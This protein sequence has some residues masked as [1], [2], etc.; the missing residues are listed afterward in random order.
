MIKEF[1]GKYRW[2]SNFT[3]CSVILDDRSYRST[4]AAYQAAKT[5]IKELRVQ[6]ETM[7]A[8]EA[9]KAGRRLSIRPDWNDI[10]IEIM[11]GLCREKFNQEPFKT[12]LLETGDQEI[13]EGNYWKDVFWGVYRGRGSN[14]LGKIIM[15][16]RDKLKGE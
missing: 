15:K 1:N 6:F 14:H 9:K 16:I 8:R 13:V 12:W 2:L 5:D 7:S 3:P 11:T 4:E 10:K